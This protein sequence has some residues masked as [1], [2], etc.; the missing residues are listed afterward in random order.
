LTSI[1][2]TGQSRDAAMASMVRTVVNF[3][4]G[5]KVLEKSTPGR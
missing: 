5:L 4:T 3:T 1:W 2:F